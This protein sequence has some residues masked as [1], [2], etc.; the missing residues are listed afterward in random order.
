V[1]AA[2]TDLVADRDNADAFECFQ[3]TVNRFTMDTDTVGLAIHRATRR[4]DDGS[5]GDLMAR[6]KI[7]YDVFCPAPEPNK[8]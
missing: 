8:E 3:Q 5:F 1:K 2:M 4:L 7:L 6:L